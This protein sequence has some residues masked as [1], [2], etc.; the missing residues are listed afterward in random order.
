VWRN[1]Y[2][3]V[4]DSPLEQM[5]YTELITKIR[6]LADIPLQL[7]GIRRSIEE[8]GVATRAVFES[9]RQ[10]EEEW[11]KVEIKFTDE[12]IGKREVDLRNQLLTQTSIKRA[13]WCTFC[14][15]AV[16][17][18]ITLLLWL[19]AQNQL[20]MEHRSW[21]VYDPSYS[22]TMQLGQDNADILVPFRLV[23]IG[24][25]PARTIEGFVIV[26]ELRKGEHPT[27]SYRAERATPIRSGIL[28]PGS[29]YAETTAINEFAEGRK[30]VVVTGAK[31]KQFEDGTT[32]FN[33]WGR[34]T[35]FDVFQ[36]QHWVQF[37]HAIAQNPSA[38]TGDCV[39]YNLVDVPG[40]W[41]A[42]SMR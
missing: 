2:A 8:Q 34:L 15:A 41:S 31:R 7:T 38:K 25:T 33:V 6:Q 4:H 37:C 32:I 20:E 1:Q 14:A 39:R 24:K 18:G 10:D 3:H 22:D 28:Y 21:L 5:N 29:E 16:Y 17:G 13:A 23:N 30:S 26:E 35:Y 27:F 36:Q 40:K 11:H 19:N 42:I 9:E 12:E